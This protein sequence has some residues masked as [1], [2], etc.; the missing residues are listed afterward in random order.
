MKVEPNSD[1]FILFGIRS[2]HFKY[3]LYKYCI[4]GKNIDLDLFREQNCQTMKIY[5][6]IDNNKY[7]IYTG[8]NEYIANLKKKIESRSRISITQQKLLFMQKNFLYIAFDNEK[9]LA[10]YNIKEGDEI[11]LIVRI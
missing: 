10:Y 9:T 3:F 2:N 7:T 8:P 6:K 11:L 4:E 1:S 5:V